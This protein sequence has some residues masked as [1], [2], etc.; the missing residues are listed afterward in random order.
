M[1]LNKSI[2]AALA[3]TVALALPSLA[4]AAPQ[5]SGDAQPVATLKIGGGVIMVS[6][7][8]SPFASG[9]ADESLYSG[10]RL[11]VSDNSSATVVYN[12]GCR[13]TY[14]KPGI[15][16][17]SATC[18]AGAQTSIKPPNTGTL[19]APARP[20]GVFV[21]AAIVTGAGVAAIIDESPR[22]TPPV[23]H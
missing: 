13:Q 19:A 14:S 5:A 15:Y 22:H 12:D 2:S 10:A 1:K 16:T 21:A 6:N 3:L 23:S 18:L 17:I 9:Q 20:M 8:G 7:Q 11:M 4:T